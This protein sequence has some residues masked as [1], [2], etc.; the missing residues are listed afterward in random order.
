[1]HCLS[2]LGWEV[3]SVLNYDYSVLDKYVGNR[4]VSYSY[5]APQ[6]LPAGTVVNLHRR[7]LAPG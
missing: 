6:A 4:Q 5:P 1:M 7:A 2:A 3:T